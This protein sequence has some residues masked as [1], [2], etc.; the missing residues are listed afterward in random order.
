[1]TLPRWE[2]R[3]QG[4]RHVGLRHAPDALYRLI[5]ALTQYPTSGQEEFA[6]AAGERAPHELEGLGNDGS[7]L[8]LAEAVPPPSGLSVVLVVH[9]REGELSTPLSNH[10][11]AGCRPSDRPHA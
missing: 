5:Q 6:D 7:G 11:L 1:M 4:G 10:D 3:V 2:L 8:Y 9:D